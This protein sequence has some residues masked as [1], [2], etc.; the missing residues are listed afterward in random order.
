MRSVCMTQ[1]KRNIRA[2]ALVGLLVAVVLVASYALYHREPEIIDPAETVGEP[3]ALDEA[4]GYSELTPPSLACT[5]RLCGTPEVDG[6]D[7]YLYLTSVEYN[8]YLI[9][10]EIYDVQMQVNEATGEKKPS[11]GKLLG[12]TGFI[13]PGTYVEKLH[14]DKGLKN[15]ENPV[16]IKIALRDEESGC[17]E[18]FFYLG[19]T[20]VK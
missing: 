5:V 14:L 18:G 10:A 4:Y 17:S 3:I 20:F 12:Q 15:G 7:V 8:A 19:T 1:L 9:R 2:G 6:K 13:H 16:Y 11:P